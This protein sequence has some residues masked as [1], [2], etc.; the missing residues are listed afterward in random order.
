MRWR[1]VSARL[2]ARAA[3][4]ERRL[5]WPGCF[6]KKGVTS[7][8]IGPSKSEHLA[9]PAALSL[10]LSTEEIETPEAL[11]CCTACPASPERSG[12]IIDSDQRTKASIL[13]HAGRVGNTG[14]NL[15]RKPPVE[16]VAATAPR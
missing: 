16:V 1:A 10:K 9:D 7:P 11:K 8:I 14:R 12:L 15:P 4:R 6:R 2:R 5:Q 3:S 13:I